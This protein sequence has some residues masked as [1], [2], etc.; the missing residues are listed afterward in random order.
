MIIL[1][2]AFDVMQLKIE[3]RKSEGSGCATPSN[4]DFKNNISEV[5][6]NRMLKLALEGYADLLD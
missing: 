1:P 6:S 3:E 5:I 4:Y 2:V